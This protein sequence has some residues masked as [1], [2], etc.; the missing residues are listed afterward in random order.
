M[1]EIK[2]KIELEKTLNCLKGETFFQRFDNLLEL[3]DENTPMTWN[4]VSR[5]VIFEFVKREFDKTA[6]R[7]ENSFEEDKYSN[8]RSELYT[9]LF[10]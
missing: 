5:D 4:G 2:L 10:K 6:D 8:F 1:R 9:Q 7:I 3:Y